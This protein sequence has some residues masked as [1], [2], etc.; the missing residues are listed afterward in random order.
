M[1]AVQPIDEQLVIVLARYAFALDPE[2]LEQLRSELTK[3]IHR[4]YQRGH[5]AGFKTGHTETRSNLERNH[6]RL[7]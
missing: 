2:S 3:I 1:R 4:A 5:R 6:A 7:F